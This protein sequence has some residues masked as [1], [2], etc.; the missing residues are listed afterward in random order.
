MSRRLPIS[1]ASKSRRL[2]ASAPGR[3]LGVAKL[4]FDAA[5]LC[6]P[7]VMDT[8]DTQI[9]TDSDQFLRLGPEVVKRVEPVLDIAPSRFDA[10]HLAHVVWCP[11]DGT[12]ADLW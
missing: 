7:A 5:V 10:V 3:T 9:D 8:A 6:A 2:N 1:T 12:P 11:L 4:G